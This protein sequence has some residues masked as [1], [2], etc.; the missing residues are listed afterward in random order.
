MASTLIYTNLVEYLAANLLENLQ[1]MVFLLSYHG[2]SGTFFVKSKEN[3]RSKLTLGQLQKIL[4]NYEFPDSAS[5]LTLLQKFGEIRN[6][7]FHRLLTISKSELDNGVVDGQFSSLRDLAEETLDKYNTITRGI[8]T[9]WSS[10][11]TQ[12]Q[13][14]QKQQSG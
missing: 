8:T 1:H 10:L 13:E 14:T 11:K 4:S 7:I 3:T 9:V 2:F 6:T 12:I 5:F